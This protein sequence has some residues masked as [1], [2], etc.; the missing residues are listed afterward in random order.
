V[1]FG[2]DEIRR[3]RDILPGRDLLDSG[4]L[5]AVLEAYC[6]SFPGWHLYYPRQRYMVAPVRALVDFLRATTA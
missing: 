2:L 5:V 6:P 4:E 1:D 3:T